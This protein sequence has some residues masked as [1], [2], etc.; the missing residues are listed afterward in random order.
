VTTESAAQAA[1][2][3]PVS[4]FAAGAAHATE[5]PRQNVATAEKAKPKTTR[6]RMCSLR[7]KA[8]FDGLSCTP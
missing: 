8:L 1:L 4:S 2:K 7:E 5:A 3:A 6:L